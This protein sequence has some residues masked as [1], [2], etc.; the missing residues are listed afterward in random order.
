MVFARASTTTRGIRAM[1]GVAR[2]I[3]LLSEAMTLEAGDV[4]VMGTPSGV[5]YGRKPPVYMKAG[6]VCEVTIERIGTLRNT[7]VDEM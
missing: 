4:L 3:A 5:G 1:F 6:D 7:V 2:T